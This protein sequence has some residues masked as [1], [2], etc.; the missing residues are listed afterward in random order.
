MQFRC[1]DGGE[2]VC[3]GGGDGDAVCGEEGTRVR[4]TFGGEFVVGEG[5]EE[6]GDEDVD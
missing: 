1:G 5:A 3:V 2:I 6:F 4:E